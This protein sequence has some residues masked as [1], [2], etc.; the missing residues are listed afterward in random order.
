MKPLVPRTSNLKDSSVVYIDL[1]LFSAWADPTGLEVLKCDSA[2]NP[3]FI[4]NSG[5]T[6]WE[7]SETFI[8]NGYVIA[9]SL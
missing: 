7:R 3:G 2:N 1:N 9:S 4:S 8:D 6:T 5:P